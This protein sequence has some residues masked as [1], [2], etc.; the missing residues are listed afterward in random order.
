MNRQSGGSGD[1]FD[2]GLPWNQPS[3]RLGGFGS[4]ENAYASKSMAGGFGKPASSMGKTPGFGK[5]FVVQKAASLD[6]REGD[7]VKH[8]Q[9][10]EGTVKSI[11]DGKRDYEITVEFDQ[12]GQ[13]RML[14]SFAK[15]EKL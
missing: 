12:A 13:K 9:F 3:A 14:A 6:Y 1:F 4:R 10:G 11:V 7:R 8:R 15:L 5:S 2:A